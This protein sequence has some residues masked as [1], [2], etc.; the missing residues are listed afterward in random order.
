MSALW[1]LVSLVLALMVQTGLSLVGPRHAAHFDA[2]LL[3]VVYAALS[4][5]ETHG[6][7][8]GALAGWIQDVQFGGTVV[9][10]SALTKLVLGFALG[11]A[12]TRFMLQGALP[13]TLVLMGA[14]LLDVL[15][16]ERL[17]AMLG[18]AVSEV[19]LAG[20]LLRATLNAAIGGLLFRALDRRLRGTAR[21]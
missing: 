14:S 11:F 20:L 6:L 4:R 5:G 9:G 2:F 3:V 18:I 16:F 15:L 17:A 10:L 7:L 1:T 12:S 13:R 21:L 19:S 8:V